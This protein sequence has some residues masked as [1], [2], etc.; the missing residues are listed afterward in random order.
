MELLH[1]GKDGSDDLAQPAATGKTAHTTVR[2]D[3][4]QSAPRKFYSREG[5][6]VLA[7]PCKDAAGESDGWIRDW[8]C[9]RTGPITAPFLDLRC[10]RGTLDQQVLVRSH[11]ERGPGSTIWLRF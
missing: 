4:R 2:V 9:T 11:G 7:Q 8:I 6:A 1:I 10:K 5:K 3:T